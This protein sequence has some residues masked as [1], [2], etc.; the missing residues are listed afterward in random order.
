MCMLQRD[1]VRTLLQIIMGESYRRVDRGVIQVTLVRTE[2]SFTSTFAKFRDFIGTLARNW[3]SLGL[4]IFE[5]FHK[6]K[7]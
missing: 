4:H 1:G 5:V 2:E 3:G 6:A 7:I